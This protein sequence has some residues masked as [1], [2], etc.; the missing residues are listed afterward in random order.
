MSQKN[1]SKRKA[2]MIVCIIVI[3]VAIVMLVC[4]GIFAKKEYDKVVS[5]RDDYKEQVEMLEMASDIESLGVEYETKVQK[6]KEL[7][8][9]MLSIS[10]KFGAD[11]EDI[12]ESLDELHMTTEGALDTIFSIAESML[13]E[14]LYEATGPS[15][16]ETAKQSSDEIYSEWEAAV[17]E[18]KEA[19]LSS[20]K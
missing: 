17:D 18:L 9:F 4:L 1:G 15:L 11:T 13:D 12:S 7:I 2:K 5:E 19:F 16:Y 6:D 8:D 20:I 14:D 10:E 3:V